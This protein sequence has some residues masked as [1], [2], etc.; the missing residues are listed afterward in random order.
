MQNTQVKEEEQE[1][2]KPHL[3]SMNLVN[4]LEQEK[5]QHSNHEIFEYKTQ[6]FYYDRWTRLILNTVWEFFITKFCSD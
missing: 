5:I 2:Y 4:F 1:Q 3:C 6:N